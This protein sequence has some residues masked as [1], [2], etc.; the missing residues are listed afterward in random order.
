MLFG[1]NFIINC[2]EKRDQFTIY[3][4]VSSLAYYYN[5]EDAFRS[6]TV[7]DLAPA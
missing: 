6:V 1:S 7:P 4:F 5:E 3:P 2:S